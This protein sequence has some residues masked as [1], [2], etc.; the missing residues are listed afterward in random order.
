MRPPSRGEGEVKRPVSQAPP[1]PV[2]N[3][4]VEKKVES[5]KQS[6]HTVELIK[7]SKVSEVKFE[8]SE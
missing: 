6:T 7:G 2:E 5:P 1:P 3:K 4:P 8:G